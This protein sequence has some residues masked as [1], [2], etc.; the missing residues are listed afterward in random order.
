MPRTDPWPLFDQ[1][2]WEFINHFYP[3]A[4]CHVQMLLYHY[5]QVDAHGVPETTTRPGNVSRAGAY[6]P[7]LLDVDWR[8]RATRRWPFPGQPPLHLQTN[9]AGGSY[10]PETVQIPASCGLKGRA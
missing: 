5:T 7:Y 3:A 9:H 6:I 8:T 4:D 2:P 10:G 1:Q